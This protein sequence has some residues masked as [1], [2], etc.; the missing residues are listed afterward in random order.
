ML[1]LLLYLPLALLTIATAIPVLVLCRRFE[2]ATTWSSAASRTR[3]ATSP[4]RSRRPPRASGCIKAFGRGKEVF[5]RYH[6]QALRAPRHPAGAHR[7]HTRFVWVL[8]LIPN[9]TLAAVLLAGALAVAAGSLTLGGLVAF[10]SYV[11]ILV[12]PLEVLGWIIA[13]AEE[14]E[15]AAGRV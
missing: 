1:L 10:V 14:A 2:R 12:C 9:L 5:E 6:A 8:V 15:T 4:P 7:L 13:M 3:P 11:L